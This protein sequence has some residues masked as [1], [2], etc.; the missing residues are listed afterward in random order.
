ML[1]EVG[2]S[3]ASIHVSQSDGRFQIVEQQF[4]KRR[5]TGSVLSNDTDSRVGM[6]SEVQL[7]EQVRLILVVTEGYVVELEH[8]IAQNFA[9][10]EFEVDVGFQFHGQEDWP[11]TG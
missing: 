8:R 5:L 3:D 10:G 7:S 9:F 4:Q 2:D 11:E 6:S 1:S